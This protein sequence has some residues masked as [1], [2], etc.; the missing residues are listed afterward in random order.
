L[1]ECVK[2]F[3]VADLALMAYLLP[4]V[5]AWHRGVPAIRSAAMINVLLGWTIVGWAVALAMA[6][7]SRTPAPSPAPTL[8]RIRAPQDAPPLR[9]W[10]RDTHQ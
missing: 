7:R 9:P 2:W 6:L 5:L 8:M 10:C 3:A 4:C 1:L